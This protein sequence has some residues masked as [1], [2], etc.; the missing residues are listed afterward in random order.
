[1][2]PLIASSLIKVGGSL[3]GGLFGRK[4]SAFKESRLAILGQAA[5]ARQAAEQYGFNPLTLLGVS[6]PMAGY[7]D[8]TMGAAIAD[9]AGALAD[10]I[11]EKASQ[12]DE[13]QKKDEEIAALRT[14][15]NSATVRPTVPGVFGSSAGSPG[16]PPLPSEDEAPALFRTIVDDTG[17]ER[18][19]P[20]MDVASDMETTAAAHLEQGTFPEWLGDTAR[21]NLPAW[22]GD[23]PRRF[24]ADAWTILNNPSMALRALRTDEVNAADDRYRAHLDAETER[25]KKMLVEPWPW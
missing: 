8:N 7:T 20:D 21:K 23:T 10:G 16:A 6:Q 12:D 11:S 4:R 5:G 24:G 2:D 3:L 18:R 13:L 1:M 19:I 17:V 25:L 15:L 22:M 9:A 14:R